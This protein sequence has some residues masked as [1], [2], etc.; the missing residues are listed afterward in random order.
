MK[1]IFLLLSALALCANGFAQNQTDDF[2]T[3]RKQSQQEFSNYKAKRDKEFNDFRDKYNAEFAE[4]MRKGWEDFRAFQGIPVPKMPEPKVPPKADPNKKPTGDPIPFS[5]VTP[6]PAPPVAPPQPVAPIPAPPVPAKQQFVFSF[7]NTECKVGLEPSQ[8]ITL[9]DVSE[10][11][12]ADAWE[13]L[14]DSRYNAAINDCLALRKQLKL[15]DWGYIQLV[16]EMSEK[17]CGGGANEA[18]LLQMFILTQS[19]YKVRIARS[20]NR[21]ALLVPSKQMMY[22]YSFLEIDGIKYYVMDKTLKGQSFYMCNQEF[23]KEQFVS[24]HLNQPN[25]NVAQT[26]RRTFASKRYPDVRVSVETNKNLINFYNAYPVNADWN[27][28]AG[29]S[30]SEQVKRDLYPA[31]KKSIAGKSEAE[32]ANILINFVQTAFEYQTDDEQF[33]YERPLFADET[34]FYPASDCE[35]RSILYSV[36]VRELLGLEVVLLHY[37]GH[38]A[39]AVRFTENVQGDYLIVEGKKFVVCDP[40]YIGANI[41]RAMEQYKNTNAKVVKI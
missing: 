1:K 38:L 11:S 16:K 39:T 17:F 28:Y 33:G 22:E 9:A 35:D 34:F 21:L 19:G 31:L 36:L 15:C 27:L 10:E 37:P 4:F 8:K 12:I 13:A 29:A 2:E 7:Y 41:G 6:T 20:G 30:L 25:F 32:A 23:P 5:E 24:L 3:F 26:S 18:V 14:S 40:T